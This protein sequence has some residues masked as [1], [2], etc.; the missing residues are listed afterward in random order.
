MNAA[1]DAEKIEPTEVQGNLA[2]VSEVEAGI[3]DFVHKCC[4]SAPTQF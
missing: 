2:A 1:T 3:R 4:Q